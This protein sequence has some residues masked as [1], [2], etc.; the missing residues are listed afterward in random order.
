MPIPLLRG[1]LIAVEGIDGSGKSTQARLLADWAAARGMEVVLSREPTS[2]PWGMK[3]RDARFKARLSPEEELEAF[4]EDRKEHVRTLIAPALARHALVIVDRYY[5]STVAYQGARGVDPRSLLAK[6]REFAPIPDM[7]ALFDLDPREGLARIQARGGG[8]D[9]FE[10]LEAL[11]KSRDIFN[12]LDEAHVVKFDAA[13][14]VDELHRAVIAA[15]LAGP[16]AEWAA[17]V[18]ADASLSD[19]EQARMLAPLR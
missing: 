4:I 10:S 11:T 3:I 7:V 9:V 15:M 18:R 8:H 5:Y 19:G 13:R 6:N 16:L 1:V 12:S 2:G 14:P 17:R